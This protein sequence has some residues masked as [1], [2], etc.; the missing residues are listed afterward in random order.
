ML[1]RIC[2]EVSKLNSKKTEHA[3]QKWAKYLK[4]HYTKEDK[5][6]GKDA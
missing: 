2:K 1:L 6:V 4:T 5:S 3:V